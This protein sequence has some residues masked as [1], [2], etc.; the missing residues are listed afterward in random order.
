MNSMMQQ[1]LYTKSLKQLIK[2]AA[3]QYAERPCQGVNLLSFSGGKDS[4]AMYLLAHELDIPFQACFADTQWERPEVYEQVEL[5]PRLCGREP[6]QT[7]RADIAPKLKKQSDNL[8]A[9]LTAEGASSE[10]IKA[11]QDR[12][13]PTHNAFVDLVKSKRQF[14]SPI[15]RF[16]TENLK[17]LPI[18]DQVYQPIWD[19]G[20]A[21][22]SWMGIRAAES[23]VRAMMPTHQNLV[24]Q[25]RKKDGVVYA[26]RP[27]L[28]WT[29]DDVWAMHE[30]HNV[31]RNKLYDLGAKR[32]GCWPCVMSGKAEI[33]N[34][35][36][37]DPE[38]IKEI[39]KLF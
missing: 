1:G 27:L 25:Y 2:D 37:V 22:V 16:C 20:N 13:T 8:T 4:T 36:R 17:I 7:V 12:L 14:P 5:V 33:A 30:R 9:K 28:N 34:V 38:K 15:K 29:L 21:V 18:R 39:E 6:I 26:F 35:A 31:P 3:K 10:C 11:E 32:V 23:Y 19:A 24:A